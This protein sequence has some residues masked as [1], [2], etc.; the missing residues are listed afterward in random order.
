MYLCS[1]SDREEAQ[2]QALWPAFLAAKV[3]GKRAQF[4]RARLVV[5]GE[6]TA[7][8]DVGSVLY[9]VSAEL[10]RAGGLSA[11]PLA[12]CDASGRALGLELLS[13]VAADVLEQDTEPEGGASLESGVGHKRK[14]SSSRYLGVRWDEGRSSWRSQM[15]DPQTKRQV[16]VGYFASEKDA[17]RGYD[18]AAVQAHGQGAERNFPGE[19][20]GELPAKVGV[21][22]KKQR[23]SSRFLGV[24]W[25]K[26]SSSW[27]VKL[28]IPQTKRD[29]SIGYFGSEEVAARAYD[30][31][32]VQARGP[33]AKR[34]FPGE[35][36][37][38][39]P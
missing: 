31:A 29:Q 33:G 18:F 36:I 37:G 11:G 32:A 39:L 34:N 22:R 28:W 17:A 15:T 25:H 4:H 9:A 16:H 27:E 3:A 19:A 26:S 35:A 24:S 2:H 20:I 13:S 12:S 30:R 14:S 21:H 7:S 23:G 10:D 6:R 5:D 1:I 38:E 8:G